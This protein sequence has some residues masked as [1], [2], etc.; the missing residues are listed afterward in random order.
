M[1]GDQK[2]LAA[3]ETGAF[4]FVS[5]RGNGFAPLYVALEKAIQS[6]DSSAGQIQ[7]KVCELKNAMTSVNG[8]AKIKYSVAKQIEGYPTRMRKPLVDLTDDDIKAMDEVWETYSIKRK[9]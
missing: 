8:I 1:G 4:G 2:I 5:A 7:A 6:G 9:A 3:Y